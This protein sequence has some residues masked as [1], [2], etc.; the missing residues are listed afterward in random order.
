MWFQWNANVL[1]NG[2]RTVISKK[3]NGLFWP[4]W[5]WICGPFLAQNKHLESVPRRRKNQL[6]FDVA[7][8][9]VAV[10]IAQSLIHACRSEMFIL[11]KSTGL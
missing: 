5:K 1:Q 11:Q 7:I 8:A 4:T 6:S 10:I 3:Y 2:R 9:V